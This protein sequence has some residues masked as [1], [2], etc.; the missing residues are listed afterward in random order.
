[1]RS[2]TTQLP[3]SGEFCKLCY[4][5]TPVKSS[6]ANVSFYTNNSKMPNFELSQ[7][8]DM[9]LGVIRSRPT[10]YSKVT[11]QQNKLNRKNSAQNK[12]MWV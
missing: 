9:Y 10:A 7:M 3:S 11:M 2:T 6:S 12:K 4:D 1:M 8:R 5:T